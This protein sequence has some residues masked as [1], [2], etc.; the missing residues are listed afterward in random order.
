[1]HIAARRI[2]DPKIPKVPAIIAARLIKKHCFRNLISECS[3]AVSINSTVFPFFFLRATERF[4]NNAIKTSAT[5]VTNNKRFR[6]R[7]N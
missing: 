7:N 4:C 1:M 3:Q 2:G 5:A 6:F